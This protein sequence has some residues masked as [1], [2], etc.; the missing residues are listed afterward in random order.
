[1]DTNTSTM[2]RG[3][4]DPLILAILENRPTHGYGLIESL[5][6]RSGGLFALPEGTVYPALYRIEQAGLIA[7]RT[8]TIGGRERRRYRL[9]ARGRRVLADRREEWGTFSRAVSNV[10]RKVP[11]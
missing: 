11:A 5:K 4:L 10:L 7:S 8:E 6:D 2:L 1:M 9:T 3:H